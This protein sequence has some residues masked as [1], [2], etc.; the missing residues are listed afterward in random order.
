MSLQPSYAAQGMYLRACQ[1][2]HV[3]V[4]LHGQNEHARFSLLLLFN[5]LAS[6]G[7][8]PAPINAVT[9]TEGRIDIV[10]FAPLNLQAVEAVSRIRARIKVEAELGIQRP[11]QF[12]RR[13]PI[14]FG[15][16]VVHEGRPRIYP[17]P[18]DSGSACSIQIPSFGGGGT[19]C[20]TSPR[21]SS[22]LPG[23]AAVICLKKKGKFLSF[24]LSS[25][26]RAQAIFMARR[27][28]NSNS[29]RQSPA[30]S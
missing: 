8:W 29:L 19:S 7:R 12:G 17:S 3:D 16:G 27:P 9:L 11:V 10:R 21:A 24:V 13:E 23:C 28:G 18:V 6:E 30:E 25:R 5:R 20:T 15:R 1:K 4:T 26:L 22:P 2:Q 14:S